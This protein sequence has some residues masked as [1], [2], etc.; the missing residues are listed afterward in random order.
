[1][2]RASPLVLGALFNAGLPIQVRAQAVNLEPATNNIIADGRTRTR[3]TTSGT[4]TR[5]TT[6]T[7]SS[8]VGFNSFSDFQQAAGT[9]VDL[10]VPDGAGN[11]IN[12]VSNGAVVINGELNA[13][14][15]GAIGGNIFFSSPDGFIVGQNGRVNVG[16]LSVNTPT[17]EFLDRVIRADGTINDAVASQLMRGEIPLSPNGHIA[18][19]GTVNATGSITLQGQTVA[20]NG[21]TGPVSGHD[22]AHRTMFE[23]TVNAH[24]MAEGGALVSSGGRIAIVATGAAQINGRVA[25]GAPTPSQSGGAVSITGGDIALGS[26]TSISADGNSGGEIIVYALGTLVAQ[27][28]ARFSAAALGTGDGGFVELSGRDAYIGSVNL[29]LSSL[30]GRAG[31][32]LVDPFNLFVGG[33]STQ[34]GLSD[35]ASITTSI[36]SNGA[37]IVLQADNSITVVSGGVLDSRRLDGGTVS[38]GDSGNIT[39]EAPRITLEDGARVLAGATVGSA[40][41]GGDVAFNAIRTGGGTVEIILG[42]SGGIGPE[43]TGRDITLTASATVDQAS[44]LLALPSATA[45][46]LSNSGTIDASGQFRAIATATGAGGLALLPLGVV[47][48]NVTAEVDIRG[49]TRLTAAAV[50]LDATAGATSSIVTQ[51]LAPA[52]SSGDGAVAVSTINSTAIAR[53][54]GQ[55][56]LTVTG[57]T[58]LS[59]TNTVTSTSDATPQAAAFGASV[60]VSIIN[61][62]TTAEIAEAAA[63][64]AGALSLN[65]TTSTE[66]TVNAVAGA[67]GATEPSPGSQ[68]STFLTDDRYGGQATTQD[69]AVSVAGALAISDLTSS[70]NARL[71]S[72]AT[73][74]VAGALSVSTSSGNRAEVT[75]DGST[76]VSDTGVGVAVGINI[77]RVVND[78]VISGAVNAGSVAISAMR[79]ADGNMFRTAATSGAGASNVGVAGSFGL[80]L[81]DVQSLARIGAA[82]ALV[83]SGGGAVLLDAQNATET[84]AQ[85]LPVGSG[86]SGAQVG[87]GASV[88][89]NI[90]A[91]RS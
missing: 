10:M 1:M 32:F 81:V 85:A 68:A 50:T 88:A 28:G 66:T 43:L 76:V 41:A 25:S 62:I 86:A 36:V 24:G 17:Q 5:I 29:N 78:A 72:I 83:I 8:G 70:T 69:G 53:T 21:N 4:Q 23:A 31:T 46:I 12:M 39:L 20:I 16:S 80:N 22:F 89:I 54:G 6:E 27:D 9:R 30:S 2:L 38:T 67:G 75:A 87:I 34:S 73:T 15:D 11:L 37:S 35:M 14:K 60:G 90:V 56:A 44:L 84:T 26:S 63:L 47:V 51:S 18:I 79:P 42:S 3:V 40:F 55:A 65:A 7:V 77:A 19:R 57:A 52:N 33:L 82:S 58:T 61:A 91:N 48:T 13:F 74:Q 71:T 64:S 45:R 59:A 49:S